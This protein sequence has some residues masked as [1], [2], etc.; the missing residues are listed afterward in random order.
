MHRRCGRFLI[1][2]SSISLVLRYRLFRIRLR[3]VRWVSVV[4]LCFL[5]WLIRMVGLLLIRVSIRIRSWR[6]ARLRCLRIQFLRYLLMLCGRKASWLRC[7]LVCCRL[8]HNYMTRLKVVICKRLQALVSSLCSRILIIGMMCNVRVLFL[9]L[10]RLFV[11][12]LWMLRCWLLVWLVLRVRVLVL[13]FVRV[14]VLVRRFRSV[15]LL[16][17]FLLLLRGVGWLRWVSVRVL[18]VRLM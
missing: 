15:L 18:V 11:S 4:G 6:V 16:L 12:V 3:W 9:R 1:A 2:L 14:R 10:L 17:L 7:L 5:S 8:V 13:R